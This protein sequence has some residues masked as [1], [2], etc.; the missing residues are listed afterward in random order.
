MTATY[1]SSGVGGF[2]SRSSSCLMIC[3]SSTSA[4]AAGME[5]RSEK[6]RHVLSESH[7]GFTQTDCVIE[8]VGPFRLRSKRAK[9]FVGVPTF[10]LNWDIP[11][12]TPGTT[13]P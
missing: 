9:A 11:A 2:A 5:V 1:G 12:T 6:G 4:V 7:Y 10:T 3:S 13:P 8:E